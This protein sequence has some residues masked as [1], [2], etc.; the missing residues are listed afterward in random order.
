MTDFILSMHVFYLTYGPTYKT[1]V[2]AS[3][4]VGQ[5]FMFNVICIIIKAS[6]CSCLYMYIK[7]F[8]ILY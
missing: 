3:V 4:Y 5:T 1:N 2:F 8:K 7:H 6:S